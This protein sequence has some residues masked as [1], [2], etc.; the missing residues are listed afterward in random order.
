VADQAALDRYLMSLEGSRVPLKGVFHAAMVI[1]DALGK[2][3]DRSRMEA[4]LRPKVAGAQ[5]LDR[6]TRRFDLDCFVLF[7]SATVLV[8]N[9]GQANPVAANA[10]LEGLAQRRRAEGLPALA[11]SWGAIGDVGYLAKNAG[12]NR[13]LAQRL[14][15]ASLTAAE[16]LAGLELLLA[17]DGR[18]VRGAAV[19][20][21]RIDW[22]LVRKELTIARTSLFEDMQLK[23]VS[24]DGASM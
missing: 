18:D 24:A 20:Y 15:S 14:G 2:D 11:V 5:H 17:G 16:A 12:V 23:D 10:F 8:G 3:L 21:A 7:S 6:L 22:S 19:G 4:V 1:D 13:A 9:P